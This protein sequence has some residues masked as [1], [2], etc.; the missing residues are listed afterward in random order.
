MDLGKFSV[1]TVVNEVQETECI[2]IL[3]PGHDFLHII[4]P[5]NIN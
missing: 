1:H 5:L 3:H 4:N 2:V